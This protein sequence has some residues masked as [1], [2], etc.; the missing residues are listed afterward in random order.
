MHCP[1]IRAIPSS[2]K[3]LGRGYV[4][5]RRLLVPGLRVWAKIY[6]MTGR[7]LA[8]TPNFQTFLTPV[9]AFFRG[10]AVLFQ[11]LPYKAVSIARL[12]PPCGT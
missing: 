6:L 9:G 3:V 4:K 1:R 2:F 7:L 11:T 12:R 8:V 5:V 10:M